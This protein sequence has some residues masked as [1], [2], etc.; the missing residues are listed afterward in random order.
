MILN[1][2]RFNIISF[3]YC[4]GFDFRGYSEG[5]CKPLVHG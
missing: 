5:L 4:I 3:L 1:I 2:D